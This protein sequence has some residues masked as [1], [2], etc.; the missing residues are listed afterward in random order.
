[1]VLWY[2]AWLTFLLTWLRG[3]AVCALPLNGGSYNV[4][5]NATTK[6]IAAICACLSILSYLAT[7]VVSAV[8]SSEGS[9]ISR[10]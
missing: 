9:L 1:M 2:W 3:Q 8:R 10:L 7:G 4:L 6:G 5:L